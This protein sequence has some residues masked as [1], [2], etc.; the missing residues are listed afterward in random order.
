MTESNEQQ[1]SRYIVSIV[2]VRQ[3]PGNINTQNKLYDVQALSMAEAHGL[4]IPLAQADFPEHSFHTV[5]AWSLAADS[6][7]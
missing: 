1:S 4:A 2:M 3:T 7:T 5:C 6:D